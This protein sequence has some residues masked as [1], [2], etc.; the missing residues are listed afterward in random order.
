MALWLRG[1]E[2]P[3]ESISIPATIKQKKLDQ[4]VISFFMEDHH[5]GRVVR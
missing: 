3:T 5:L 2:G 1:V 4:G